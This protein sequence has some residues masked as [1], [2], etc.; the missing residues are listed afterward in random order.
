LKA[1]TIFVEHKK[2]GSGSSSIHVG[3][4]SQIHAPEL[5]GVKMGDPHWLTEEQMD[6]L[7]FPNRP[8]AGRGR[9]AVEQLL[10]VEPDIGRGLLHDG[11][12]GRVRREG[13]PLP[14]PN[15]GEHPH[16][17]L[18]LGPDG[19]DADDLAEVVEEAR[20]VERQGRVALELRVH[21]T[22]GVKRILPPF[23]SSKPEG[24]MSAMVNCHAPIRIDH[25]RHVTERD[26]QA[27]VVGTPETSTPGRIS[28]DFAYVIRTDCA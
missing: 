21:L 6:R 11:P 5:T 16:H 2:K 26:E 19:L 18:V 10:Q 20:V 17:H 3:G 28:G 15:G 22:R 25:A 8:V 9:Q 14:N 13:L 27:V 1:H 7:F 23:L 24:P 4:K 12:H